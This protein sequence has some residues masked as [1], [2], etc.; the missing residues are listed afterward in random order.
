MEI[1]NRLIKKNNEIEQLKTKVASLSNKIKS[2]FKS[3]TALRLKNAALMT[4]KEGNKKKFDNIIQQYEQTIE[5]LNSDLAQYE[6]SEN[7]MGIDDFVSPG[8]QPLSLGDSNLNFGAGSIM[9]S[10]LLTDRSMTQDA[11]QLH[12][13]EAKIVQEEDQNLDIVRSREDSWPNANGYSRRGSYDKNTISRGR[14]LTTENSI[15]VK[16]LTPEQLEELKRI[17]HGLFDLDQIEILSEDTATFIIRYE[18]RLDEIRS[19]SKTL[20]ENCNKLTQQYEESSSKCESLQDKVFE[21]DDEIGLLIKKL[22]DVQLEN[23]HQMNSFYAKLN[24]LEKQVK[25]QNGSARSSISEN[26]ILK[27]QPKKQS[28]WG[29]FSQG[30]KKHIELVQGPS[31]PSRPLPG[32]F[33]REKGTNPNRR[34]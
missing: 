9:N 7:N 3:K 15:N 4:Q 18:K 24:S 10:T 29:M 23:A 27:V 11:E 25:S 22:T 21:K 32:N 14:T 5:G 28:I 1:K 30:V 13:P 12:I 17:P 6:N 2:L 34:R 26:V 19:N 8:L 16:K 33:Q 20:E 31:Q